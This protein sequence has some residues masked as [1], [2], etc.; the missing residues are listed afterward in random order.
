M[1]G[2]R[3][4]WA[5]SEHAWTDLWREREGVRG[6]WSVSDECV[7]SIICS[8]SNRNPKRTRSTLCSCKCSRDAL[9]LA[10]LC[11]FVRSRPK[12]FKV[13]QTRAVVESLRATFSV[14]EP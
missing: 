3:E 5:S 13:Y 14:A 11:V 9:M 2:V 1:C 7:Q 6:V 4:Q 10:S 8:I 12:R